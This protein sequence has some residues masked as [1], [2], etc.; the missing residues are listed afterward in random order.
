MLEKAR[1]LGI[2]LASSQEFI[3]MRQAQAELEQNEAVSA[4]MSELQ[5]KRT[6]LIAL[7]ND[8]SGDGTGA[9]E[10]SSDVE[11]LQ[12][13]LQENPLFIELVEAE[14][15]FSALISAVDREINA[16]IGNEQQ[17][18]SGQCGSCAG[19]RH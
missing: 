4:L 2:A 1:E 17:G 16:C 12:G 14:G 13:Q 5:Q 3:R 9:L 15:A 18:C 8:E 10:L 11:R 6:E 7:L 19:C